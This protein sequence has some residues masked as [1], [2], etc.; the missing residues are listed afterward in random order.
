MD[1]S[2]PISQGY[3]LGI[4]I[5]K[6]HGTYCLYHGGGGFGFLT[7]M[8]WCPEYGIG[9]IVLTN[10]M[11]NGNQHVKISNEI[12]EKLVTE[13]IVTKDTS[14]DIR[15]ADSLIGK[16]MKLS[17]LPDMNDTYTPTPYKLK[18]KRYVGTYRFIYRG[19]KLH[20]VAKLAM[21]LGYCPAELKMTVVEKDG[22]LCIGDKKLEE[23]E[24]GLF[25]T[26]SGEALDMRGKTP[27][28]RNIKM[29]KSVFFWSL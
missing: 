23:Y 16:D 28:W 5:L 21:A 9:C 19:Y 1:T 27:T 12:L 22:Y 14:G 15:S 20:P 29:E 13:H 6:G 25:F 26:P 17:P 2:S 3:G 10:S 18:W 8:I 4:N 11:N 7:T 24:P